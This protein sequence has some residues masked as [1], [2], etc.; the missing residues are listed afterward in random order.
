M[1]RLYRLSLLNWLSSL[2]Q[3]D[4][5]SVLD[6]RLLQGRIKL[7]KVKLLLLFYYHRLRFF[8]PILFIWSIV[9]IRLSSDIWI[10]YFIT[11]CILDIF[12]GIVFIPW[13]SS[14]TRPTLYLSSSSFVK[15]GLYLG[16]NKSQALLNP[17]LFHIRMTFFVSPIT[18]ILFFLLLLLL[19]VIF[20]NKCFFR[21]LLGI[22]VREALVIDSQL[23]HF[24]MLNNVKWMIS[25]VER[26]LELSTKLLSFVHDLSIS[27]DSLFSTQM[28]ADEFYC[29]KYTIQAEFPN[30]LDLRSIITQLYINPLLLKVGSN[31][32]L[33]KMYCFNGHF[34]LKI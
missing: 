4:Q 24:S 33:F 31:I 28:T 22:N 9:I 25:N 16:G 12:P 23:K 18:I 20:I 29:D 11:S 26:I 7:I 15:S 30:E 17:I 8:L 6:R 3:V 14:W 1:W 13:R 27:E 32:Y 34:L 21:L 2:Q 19:S 5:V 10:I